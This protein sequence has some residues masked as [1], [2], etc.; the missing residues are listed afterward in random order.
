MLLNLKSA[1][2][3]TGYLCW[4][5]AL[6]FFAYLML[7]IT[8]QYIPIRS[9][10]AFLITKQ[11]VVGHLYYR[12]A[13]FT[14]VYTGMFVLLAAILQFLPYM[15]QRFPRVHKWSGRVYAGL[16]IFITGPA[17]FIMG[18]YGN[19]GWVA[20]LAF[21]ML[22]I[23]WIFFTWKATVLAM[24][25]KFAAH[26]QWMYR[27]YALTLSAISLRAWRWGLV[28]LF[29]PRPMDVY[30]VVAWLGWGGNLLIAE[31]IIFFVLRKGMRLKKPP[32]R[33]VS[34]EAYDGLSSQV[35]V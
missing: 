13:F 4:Y 19:G 29:Q 21:C 1:L 35:N 2:N 7:L 30:R 23:L 10:A 25:R 28:A 14:H 17:G 5:A 34:V 6:L 15:R 31:L 11:D 20:Q 32:A 24:Q 8:L 22:A 9:D 12:I 16:V 3:K 33:K 26:K 27:S 18:V